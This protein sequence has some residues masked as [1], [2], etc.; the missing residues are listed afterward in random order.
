MTVRLDHQRHAVARHGPHR[1]HDVGVLAGPDRQPD[2]AARGQT[3]QQQP[4]GDEPGSHQHVRDEVPQPP[5]VQPGGDQDDRHQPVVDQPPALVPRLAARTAQREDDDQHQRDRRGDRRPGRPGGVREIEDATARAD[6]RTAPRPGGRS[7][8]R[9]RSARSIGAPPARSRSRSV[10]ISQGSR[11]GSTTA[12]TS[13]EKPTSPALSTSAAAGIGVRWPD[14][15]PREEQRNQQDGGVPEE[16][17]EPGQR[18]M[19]TF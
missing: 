16:P 18:A 5:D 4:A 3:G 19:Y 13:A 14:H 2:P 11:A 7:P 10:A 1:H 12:T 6:R 15:T 8:A 17:G 9:P